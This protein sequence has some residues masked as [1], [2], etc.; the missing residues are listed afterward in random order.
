LRKRR[1]ADRHNRAFDT[2][3]EKI[4]DNLNRGVSNDGVL[5]CGARFALIPVIAPMERHQAA[6]HGG[7]RGR[8]VGS[9]L[10]YGVNMKPID[11]C[12]RILGTDTVHCGVFYSMRNTKARW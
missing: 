4:W 1:G 6:I 12:L 7:R 10:F 11:N 8:R 3:S 2:G 5:F 9:R